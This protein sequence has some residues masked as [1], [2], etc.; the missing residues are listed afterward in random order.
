M[1]SSYQLRSEI[2][3]C[4]KDYAVSRSIPFYCSC[5]K[6]PTI[7]F[8]P[9]DDGR[10]HGNFLPATYRAILE[11]SEWAPRLEKPHHQRSTALPADKKG[12]ARELDSSNS[13][14]ALLMNVL[15][16]P[17]VVDS[18]KIAQLF[19]C[20]R[21][22]PLSFGHRAQVPRTGKRV[23]RTEVDM[24]VADALVEAKLTE[25]DFTSKSRAHVETYGDFHSVFDASS[26]PQN[27]EKYHGYQ[28]IR[29]VL[30]AHDSG[31][32]FYLICDERR[33][34]LIGRWEEVTGSVRSDELRARCQYLLWQEIAA[35][36]PD[37]LRRFLE[38][39]YGIVATSR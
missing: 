37:E 36:A 3:K 20:D 34:D 30:A 27:A 32:K 10:L 22:E 19:G 9:Y 15:C 13:S 39:K 1:S 23:D 14:D 26:L 6:P 21:L 33:P 5:G 7:L 24:R 38:A 4:A 35:T 31:S 16:Y 18:P 17:G 25:Q 11:N 29:N 12:N 28:L 8:E 2:A